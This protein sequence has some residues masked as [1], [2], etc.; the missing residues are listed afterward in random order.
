[1]N[2]SITDLKMEI[3]AMKKLQS[4]RILEM[5]KVEKGTGP[6]YISIINRIQEMEDRI[7]GVED[8]I[9]EI[10]ATVKENGNTKGS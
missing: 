5:E 3:E 8:M 4:E 6:T 10:N 9:E 7:S 2:T 1:M